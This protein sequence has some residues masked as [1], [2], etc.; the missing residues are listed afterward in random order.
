MSLEP[1]L[2]PVSSLG[3]HGL[4]S[5]RRSRSLPASPDEPPMRSGA[6]IRWRATALTTTAAAPE[7]TDHH[8]VGQR[9]RP[10]PRPPRRPP[11]LADGP[12]TSALAEAAPSSMDIGSSR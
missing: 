2:E 5:L 6:P 9:R 11:L 12:P 1:A 8:R 10:P 4:C 7:A 3:I